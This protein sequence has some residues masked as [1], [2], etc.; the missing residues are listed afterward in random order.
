ME[1]SKDREIGRE[2]NRIHL[3][4]TGSRLLDRFAG[5]LFLMPAALLVVF[6]LVYPVLSSLYYSFTDRNL[7]KTDYDFIGIANYTQVF[8]DDRFWKA[9]SNSVIWTVASVSLQMLLGFGAALL[10]N[11][12][13]WFK[14]MFR[15]VLI[16]PWAFPSLVIAFTWTWL[17]N[18]QYGF[19][20]AVLLAT[21][22]IRQP[23]L[24]LADPDLA[25]ISMVVINVWFGFP[26]MMVSILAALQTI[27]KDEY[28]AA[29]IDGASA[30]QSFVH[31]TFKHV[32]IILGL[33]ATVRT[34]WVFNNF[35]FIFLTTGGGPGNATETLPLYAYRT[36]WVLSA[37]GKSSAIATILVL[38]LIIV[39]SVYLRLLNRW[40]RYDS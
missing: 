12:I 10:L 30:W 36:G 8:L 3:F 1:V 2:V 5:P 17:M 18:D 15:T 21:G 16:I 14:G 23:I 38:L 24:W 6:V 34:I 28:E 25:M 22:L 39:T 27:P 19:I 32:R 7:L 26:F 29:A 40:E 11:R 4:Q 20:N 35:E 37:L 33:I 31:I 9:L 13:H